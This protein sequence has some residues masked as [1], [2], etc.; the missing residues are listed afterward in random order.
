MKDM[1]YRGDYMKPFDAFYAPKA[2]EPPMAE[3][4]VEKIENKIQKEVELVIRQV[5]SA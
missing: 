5:R 4:E 3:R 1:R 2:M